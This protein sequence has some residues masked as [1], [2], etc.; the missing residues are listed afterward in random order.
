MKCVHCGNDARYKD[1]QDG[2]C[3][4]CRREFAFEP[5]QGAL[6]T[7]AGFKAAIDAVSA[8]GRVRWGVEHLYYEVCRRKRRR[9]P[10]GC[11]WAFGAATLVV[12]GV[13]FAA[14][15]GWWFAAVIATA[16]LLVMAAYRAAPPKTVRVSQADFDRMWSRWQAVQGK[17]EG[18]IVRPKQEARRRPAE[19]DLGDYSFDR[20]VI[21][22][23]A[24]TVDLLLANNFHFENNCAVL[25]VNGYPAGPFETVQAMLRRNPRLHVFAL[26]DATPEGCRLAHNL[27]DDPRW[28]QGH[29]A[30]TDVGLRPEHAGPFVGLLLPASARAEAGRGISPQEADWLSQHALELAAIRPE[31]VLKRL[32]RAIN[33][34]LEASEATDSGGG[35]DGGGDGGVDIDLG[36]FGDDAGDSDGGADGFG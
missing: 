32:Y 9:L 17:P 13:A 4:G 14:G 19:P 28:F 5:K 6:M 24:R 36:S 3:P 30:V 33:R 21:C 7:D 8:G 12:L 29:A 22:D 15:G 35:G 31:Q 26:H 27:A 2:R 10:A 23:R 1:R 25:S 11:V 34:K 20:A 18:L 16:I